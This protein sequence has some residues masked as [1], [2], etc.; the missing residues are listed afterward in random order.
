[1]IRGVLFV[2]AVPPTPSPGRI[3]GLKWLTSIEGLQDDAVRVVRADGVPFH[4]HANWIAGRGFE[5][6]CPH[7][8]PGSVESQTVLRVAEAAGVHE[9]LIWVPNHVYLDRPRFRVT[10]KNRFGVHSTA[11][12][13][14]LH[15]AQRVADSVRAPNT[16]LV[17]GPTRIAPGS[18]YI[19]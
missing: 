1:M 11:H 6:F 9:Y 17:E 2:S 10:I 14:A 7:N 15:A 16:F 13:L 8:D 12:F 18:K 3:H 5:V 19:T 4:I